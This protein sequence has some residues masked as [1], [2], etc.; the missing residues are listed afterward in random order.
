VASRR[1]PMVL[2]SVFALLA[3]VLAAVGIAGVVA[4][5]VVQRSQ[6]IGVRM[7]LGA[8]SRHVLRLV[9]G[10]SMLW[11]L[12]GLAGGLLGSFGL[13]RLLG[14]LLYDVRPTDPLVLASVSAI[15]AGVALGASVIPARR[16]TRV[17]PLQALRAE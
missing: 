11:M 10:Q 13:L 9:V 6:E 8:Q 3:L 16:A 17:D 15:V 4:Y 7:A 12:G 14:S 5:T 2:L 1:Y